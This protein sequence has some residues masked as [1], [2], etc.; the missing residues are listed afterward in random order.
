VCNQLRSGISG[1]VYG[2]RLPPCR[3]DSQ[4]PDASAH[5]VASGIFLG[6][7]IVAASSRR[8]KVEQRAPNAPDRASANHRT[9][10]EASGPE[11]RLPREL[12]GPSPCNCALLK[13]L[14][15]RP[16]QLRW[17]CAPSFDPSFTQEGEVNPA[18]GKKHSELRWHAESTG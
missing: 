15:G 1:I 5:A 14:G 12:S 18:L 7:L 4:G 3:P 17:P 8:E 13:T 6:K 16:E 2:G 9:L 10:Y 11:L